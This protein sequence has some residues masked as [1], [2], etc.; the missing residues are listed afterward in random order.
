MEQEELLYLLALTNSE[1]VGPVVAR[2]LLDHFGT[3]KQVF[4]ERN[5]CRATI[6]GVRPKFLSSIFTKFNLLNAE[7]ELKYINDNQLSYCHISDTNY[8]P[9]LKN[10]PDAPLLL[11][12]KGAINFNIQRSLSIV[13]TRQ[14]T[15]YGKATLKNLMTDLKAYNPL[16]VSGLAYGV[17]IYAHRLAMEHDMS[18][19]G[20]VAHGLDRIYPAAHKPIADQMLAKGGI[21]TDFWSGTNPERENFV[22]RNRIV[23]GISQ[24]TI[25]IESAEKGGSLITADLANSYH[26]DVFAVPGRVTDAFSVGCNQLIK[27][28]RAAVLTS[29][30]DIAYIL[31]WE[32]HTESQNIQHELFIEL[33]PGEKQ[34]Y[35]YLL[36]EGK[37]QLDL[38][39]LYCKLPTYK[40]ASI[41]FNLEMKGMIRPSPG[42][43]FEAI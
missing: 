17:D 9:R 38:I 12:Y 42:K 5:N 30:K 32:R 27:T 16:I 22:K 23:A 3:A 43:F 15:A 26:R 25:V 33:P 31:N 36:K 13:G 28:N 19:I 41:L 1:G 11:F 10:C 35:Q 37:T 7:R 8:P 6:P 39:S 34:V 14:M 21:L 2:K 4:H 20:V 24:A 18:T 29:A 40:I